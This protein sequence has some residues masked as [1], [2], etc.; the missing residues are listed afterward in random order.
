VQVVG[1][2][3]GEVL[4]TIRIRGDRFTPRVFASGR[5]TVRVVRPDTEAL[6]LFPGLEPTPDSARVLELDLR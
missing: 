4:Y 6:L 2:S 5:Y 3:D 1:E